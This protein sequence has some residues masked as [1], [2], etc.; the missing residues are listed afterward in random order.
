MHMDILGTRTIEIEPSRENRKVLGHRVTTIVDIIFAKETK[1]QRINTKRETKQFD[2]FAEYST[3]SEAT[4][5]SANKKKMNILIDKK[6]K[7][8]G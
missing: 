5:S 3:Q 6:R 4:M 2:I 1:T 8:D 7:L